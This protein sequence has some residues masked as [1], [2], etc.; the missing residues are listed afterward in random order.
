MKHID[1]KAL[2][3]EQPPVDPHQVVKKVQTGPGA[4]AATQEVQKDPVK[5]FRMNTWNL[6][7]AN[8]VIYSL[9]QYYFGKEILKF[10]GDDV[11]HN[12]GFALIKCKDTSLVV[13]GK[14]KTILLE[15]CQNVK[16]V[17]DSILSNVELINCKKVSV[18]VKLQQT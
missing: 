11:Q 16:V 3:Q 10:S 6:V 4:K 18:Q 13:E 15:N 1:R 8:V 9:V 12:Y 14:C 5:E 17:V 7:S 2:K